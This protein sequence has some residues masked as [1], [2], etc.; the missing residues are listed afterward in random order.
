MSRPSTA[1]GIARV[2]GPYE[3]AINGMLEHP[4]AGELDAA[5]EG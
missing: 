1:S 3:L 4:S 5:A 2:P